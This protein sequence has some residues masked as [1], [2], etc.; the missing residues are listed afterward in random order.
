MSAR[1]RWGRLGSAIGVLALVA[2]TGAGAVTVDAA[3]PA[4]SVAPPSGRTTTLTGHWA[5]AGT[6]GIDLVQE[7]S[8]LHGT[9]A[10]GITISGTVDGSRV[11]FRWWRGASYA[12]AKQADRGTGT[13]EISPDRERLTIAAKGDDAGPGPFPTRLDAVRVHDIVASPSPKPWTW[14]YGLDPPAIY[15]VTRTYLDYVVESYTWYLQN[16]SWPSATVIW[17]QLEERYRKDDILVIGGWA[18][19]GN[20][21]ILLIPPWR[22]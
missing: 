15:S 2:L 14:W 8:T 12:K 20:G 19:N 16:G 4:P 13:M 3:S 11:T 9:S 5:I 6:S 7:G 1:R 10:A 17:I 21:P 22:R 18:A